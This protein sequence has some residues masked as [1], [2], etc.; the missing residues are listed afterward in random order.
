M[1]TSCLVAVTVGTLALIGPPPVAHAD[2]V[3]PLN[4]TY[5]ATSLG[6]QAKTNSRV[7]EQAIVRS[8][9]TISTTCSFADLCAG[10]VTSD[11]GW[12]AEVHNMAGQWFVRRDLPGWAPCPD[13]VTTSPGRQI[14]K[15]YPADAR[16]QA[17]RN[18]RTW[19]GWDET[20]GVSGACGHNLQQ[21]ITMPFRLDQIS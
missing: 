5:R 21:Q 8:T 13:G 4:G 11:Q 19:A 18:S 15:F 17:V 12:S 3:G 7:H 6:N 2:S 9:W 10:T 14:F 16:G 20:T 1:R